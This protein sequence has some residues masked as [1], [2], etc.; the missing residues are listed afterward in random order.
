VAGL[1]IN[2]HSCTSGFDANLATSANATICAYDGLFGYVGVFTDLIKM[3]EPQASLV[4]VINT[5]TAL[6]S[7]SISDLSR[8]YLENTLRPVD[9]ARLAAARASNYLQQNPDVGIILKELD[10]LLHEAENLQRRFVGMPLPPLYGIPFTVDRLEDHAEVDVLIRAGALLVGIIPT[11]S[12]SVAAL[13]V[14]FALDCKLSGIVRAG[15]STSITVFHPTSV[16]SRPPT[17]RDARPTTIVA[18][19]SEE[20]RK[21]WL[22]IEQ[23]ASRQED[24]FVLS[25]A[26]VNSWIWHVD[27][28]GPKSGGFVFGSLRSS[29]CCSDAS[30]HLPT[31]RAIQQLEAAGGKAQE[32]DWS[33]F[34]EAEE[35]TRDLRLS[36]AKDTVSMKAGLEL[37]TRHMQLSRQAAKILA[38]VDV[39]FDPMATCLCHS[40]SERAEQDHSLVD[41]LNFCSISVDPRLTQTEQGYIGT[42]IMLVG[43]TGRDGRILDIAREL[44][45]TMLY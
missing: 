22:V 6:G 2:N 24:T 20:A 27:F 32:I 43:A 37:Q 7:M 35:V 4:P 13:S 40:A 36:A 30:R 1:L 21:V 44:E 12:A 18:Q 9:I 28:R 33:I 29:S 25:R 45:K 38:T 34:E 10:V 19:S 41:S 3:C 42:T 15:A 16:D 8:A 5:S 31:A 23:N 39:L 17:H 26:V 14:S 11:T